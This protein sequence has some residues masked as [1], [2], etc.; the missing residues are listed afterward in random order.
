MDP[1]DTESQAKEISSNQIENVNA[2][3]EF[4]FTPEEEKALVKKVDLTLLPTIWIMYLLSYLDRT[5]IGN[6]KISGMEV[7]LNL[8]SNQYSIALVVFF[9]GYVVLE[10]PSNL[11]L[12]RSRP[13]IFLP[14][15]MILWGALT[16]VMAVVKSFAHLV[17]L[18]TILGCIEA[19]FAPGVLLLISS[20]YKQ[21]EQSK[22]FGVFIS[23]AVLSGAFGGLIAAGIV[24][25]LEG[26]C[27]IRGWR[28][29]FIIEGAITVGFAII[30]IF[31]LPDFPATTKRLSDRERKIA[32]ARL[33]KENVTASSEATERLSNLGACKVAC[34]DYRTWAFVIG[35]MVI[36]GSSTLTYFYPTLVGGLF[37][38]ASTKRINLL[39]VPIYAV[40]FVA[41]GVTSYYGDKVP[42]WRGIIIAGWLL[43]SLI[44]AI[45]VCTIYNFAARYALL[46]LIA[47]GLWSTNGG[48]LAYASSAFAGMHPQAR[49]V[50]L[51]MV[52]A[53]GNLAQ[54]Y[55]SYLFPEKDGPKYIMGFSVISAMLAVGVTVFL[56]LQFRLY[57]RSKGGVVQ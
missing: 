50:S 30:S 6:A 3:D 45:L 26:A 38:D 24:D 27:G 48:T 1:V 23:A 54:I 10:V 43:F 37:G 32:V 39:T 11:V 47:A 49:G 33:A 51:A 25:G 29:L 52:N 40:A 34:Q 21:T 46:V 53:L 57:R 36:V 9:V 19:G 16:C 22:R 41:T 56:F 8:T 44:C 14:S 20:W 5:N 31:I 15:I 13:S 12:G 42:S 18:R 7:D 2:T 28:W 4:L 55:G 17:I 35:Y